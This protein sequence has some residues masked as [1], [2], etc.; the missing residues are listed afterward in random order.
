MVDASYMAD[1]VADAF[2]GPSFATLMTLLVL[3]LVVFVA[4]TSAPPR[5][6]PPPPPPDGHPADVRHAY[7][8]LLRTSAQALIDSGCSPAV[9][10]FWRVLSPKGQTILIVG[11][12]NAGKTALFMRVRQAAYCG[13]ISSP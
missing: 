11:P 3:I 5:P 4:S 2:G 13:C 1:E 7:D 9:F 10:A 6:P 8:S 12:S